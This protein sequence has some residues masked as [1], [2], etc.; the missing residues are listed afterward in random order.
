[1]ITPRRS[2]G[3]N[4]ALAEY[5]LYPASAETRDLLYLEEFMLQE[6]EEQGC[7]TKK[8]SLDGIR[9]MNPDP[10]KSKPVFCIPTGKQAWLP[11]Q[12][13]KNSP[14]EIYAIAL[15][16]F[17][18]SH[19]LWKRRFPASQY[20]Q[21]LARP[22]RTPRRHSPYCFDRTCTLSTDQLHIDE[23]IYI[24][25]LVASTAFDLQIKKTSPTS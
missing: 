5:S 2:C 21:P 18:V 13:A 20:F 10:R 6:A 15:Y 8:W 3:S 4:H 25:S 24:P 11:E 12:C 14:F 1:L 19:G 16:Q 23:A 22:R 7:C 17:I 9:C